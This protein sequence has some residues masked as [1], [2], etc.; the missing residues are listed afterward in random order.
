MMPF[1]THN[2]KYV[3]IEG[4]SL[5][6]EFECDYNTIKKVFGKPNLGD[7][8]KID[9]EWDIEFEDGLVATV[10]NWKNGKSYLGSDGA[11]K[12]KINYWHIGG[13]SNE[14]YYRVVEIIRA[15]ETLQ[16]SAV[17]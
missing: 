9:A 4:T 8:Y 15:V 11:P 3:R 17:L 16:R 14:A 10:Y 5:Q 7:G 13:K 12:T 6:G 1:K 2:Q